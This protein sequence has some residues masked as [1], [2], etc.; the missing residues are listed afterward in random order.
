MLSLFHPKILGLTLLPVLLAFF[1]WGGLTWWFWQDWVTGV[2]QLLAQTPVDEYLLR[3]EIH[4][5]AASVTTV[6]LILLL[7]PV[8]LVTA[9]LV[10]S[11][12]AMPVMVKHVGTRDFPRLE[13]KHGGTVLGSVCNALVATVIFIL[14]WMVTLPLW[15]FGLPAVALPVLLSAY[16][17]QRLFRYDALAEHASPEEFKRI[18]ERAGARLYLLGVILALIQLVPL[19]NLFSPVY[20]GLA[21]IHFCLAEL[22]RIRSE[23]V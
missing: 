10:T 21:Y 9:L 3:H 16:L 19:L 15:L 20:I 14:L 5:L 11:V 1:L 22:Q 18:L 23:Q 13:Q 7:F 8:I 4:W 17:S 6:L 12:L 2:N